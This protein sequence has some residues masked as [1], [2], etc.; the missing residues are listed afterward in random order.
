MYCYP[1]EAGGGPSQSLPAHKW[2]QR[3]N[4]K[5]APHHE[6]ILPWGSTIGGYGELVGSVRGVGQ[7]GG[8]RER[9]QVRVLNSTDGVQVGGARRWI[10][11]KFESP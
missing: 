7:A 4:L 6:A 8:V 5:P 10:M 3:Q 9:V 2:W 11:E 1:H